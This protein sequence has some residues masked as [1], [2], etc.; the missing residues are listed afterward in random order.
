MTNKL[1]TAPNIGGL[2]G[3]CG[4]FIG[5]VGFCAIAGSWGALRSTIWIGLPISL[6]LGLAVII[7]VDLVRQRCGMNSRLVWT[8]AV[9]MVSLCCA[10]LLLLGDHWLLPIIR[11]DPRLDTALFNPSKLG[12]GWVPLLLTASTILLGWTAYQ[13][14]RPDSRAS[15]HTCPEC[16]TPIANPSK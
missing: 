10:V 4:W 12:D 5:F 13:L 11:S 3:V 15:S 7:S 14:N 2:I 8:T 16:G 1:F 9:G 6:S